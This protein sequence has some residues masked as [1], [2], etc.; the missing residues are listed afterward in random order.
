MKYVWSWDFKHCLDCCRRQVVWSSFRVLST[1]RIRRSD[2][3]L[4]VNLLAAHNVTLCHNMVTLSHCLMIRNSHF[5][6]SSAPGKRLQL[7]TWTQTFSTCQR[8]SVCITREGPFW[9]KKPRDFRMKNHGYC[10]FKLTIS[11]GSW[12]SLVTCLVSL[13]KLKDNSDHS[14]AN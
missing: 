14:S 2:I 6:H 10:H 8:L 11:C 3:H 1:K 12:F 13:E 5:T 9:K 4:E 7:V